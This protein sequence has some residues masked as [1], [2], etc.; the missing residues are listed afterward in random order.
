MNKD[1]VESLVSDLVSLVYSKPGVE[2]SGE[3]S[4]IQAHHIILKLPSRLLYL[5]I[6]QNFEFNI[7]KIDCILD[8]PHYL[9]N[10]WNLLVFQLIFD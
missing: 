5:I 7:L 6:L 2:A 4:I 8:R 9:I 10:L 1:P 3:V